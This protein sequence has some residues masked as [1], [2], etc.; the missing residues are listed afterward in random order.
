[1]AAGALFGVGLL[2]AG[3]TDPAKVLGFL[4][5]TGKWDASLA[6]VMVGAIGVHLALL[7]RIVKL[8]NPLFD[9]RF[10]LPSRRDIDVRLVLGAAVFG[11]GWGL[12]GVCPG[13]SFVLAGTGSGYAL[14]FVAAMA[15]GAAL[16][17]NLL[18]KRTN[19]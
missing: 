5:V 3:M 15:A 7:R 18:P 10:H 6:F 14:A 2:V 16:V 13:P 1:M 19:G 9:A 11:I 4:D 12:G 17:R 8:P